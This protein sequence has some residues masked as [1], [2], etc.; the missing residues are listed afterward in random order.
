MP[1]NIEREEDV[2]CARAAADIVDD[3]RC[4]TRVVQA[5]GDDA[6]MRAAVGQDL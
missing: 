5:L 4:A 6:D 2:F 1:G 3:E